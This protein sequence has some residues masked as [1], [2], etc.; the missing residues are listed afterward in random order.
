MKENHKSEALTQQYCWGQLVLH[1]I[2]VLYFSHH[3]C[4]LSFSCLVSQ[5]FQIP[6]L[7]PSFRGGR[8]KDK[9]KQNKTKNLSVQFC[10]SLSYNGKAL[11]KIC[12][13]LPIP[14]QKRKHL[15]LI[16]D[17]KQLPGA[18]QMDTICSSGNCASSSQTAFPANANS[19]YSPKW[20]DIMPHCE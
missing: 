7:Y 11:S 6:S 20:Y 1:F 4:L 8:K 12:I 16:K 19:A 15:H 18:F 2:L 9:K 3:H 10:S 13:T 14:T 5:F 17:K